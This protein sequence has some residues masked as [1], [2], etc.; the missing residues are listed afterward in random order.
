LVP[1]AD[2]TLRS[3]IVPVRSELLAEV[4]FFGRYRSGAIRGGVLLATS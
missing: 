3:V 4:K 1:R 2:P